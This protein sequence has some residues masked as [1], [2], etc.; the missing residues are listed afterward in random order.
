MLGSA[1]AQVAATDLSHSDRFQ[2]DR[3]CIHLQTPYLDTSKKQWL[4]MREP[5]FV[6]S[7]LSYSFL[8]DIPHSI[9]HTHFDV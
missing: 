8:S 5:V 2:A 6:N 1:S 3:C 9:F 7:F 4:D